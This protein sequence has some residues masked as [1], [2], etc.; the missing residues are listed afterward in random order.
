MKKALIGYGGHA[1]EVIAQTGLN[2]K[3]FVEFEYM[4]KG[5][6][7]LSNFDPKKFEV[8]VAIGDPNIRKN[9]TEK[10]PKNTKYFT[11]IHPTAQI[12]SKDVEIGEG[13]FIGA[14]SIITTNVKIGKHSILN[15]GCQIGH[16]TVCGDF[17]SMMPGSIIS[18]NCKIGDKVYLGTN[19]SIREKINICSNVT[20][21]LNGGVVDEIT[22]EGIYVGL[23]VKKIKN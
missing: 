7:L 4:T 10:L 2:L 15:R 1:R 20:I 21:G 23:P 13:S 19:S 11:F 22:E 16:D 3:C 12:M 14:N 6:H 18:G 8:I 5:T 17:L 9:I